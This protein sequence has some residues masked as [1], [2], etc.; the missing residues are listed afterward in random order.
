MSHQTIS[1]PKLIEEKPTKALDVSGSF[2]KSLNNSEQEKGNE[3]SANRTNIE[4]SDPIVLLDAS[5][6]FEEE[7]ELA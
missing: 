6:S 5:I 7:N 2:L 3:N 1:A 4:E